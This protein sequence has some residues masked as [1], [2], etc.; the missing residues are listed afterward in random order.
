M[1]AR[2]RAADPPAP[3]DLASP[4]HRAL[5]GS[6]WRTNGRSPTRTTGE[7]SRLR[8][9]TPP[10]ESRAGD[11]PKTNPS[12]G[13][14]RAASCVALPLGVPL[15]RKKPRGRVGTAAFPKTRKTHESADRKDRVDSSDAT[16]VG[17]PREKSEKS[18]TTLLSTHLPLRALL[19]RARSLPRQ[20]THERN[21]K[22]TLVSVLPLVCSIHA[23]DPN[24][25]PHATRRRPSRTS[26]PFR[27][28]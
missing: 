8:A 12:S 1:R 27:A 4:R 11:F 20:T 24:A 9:F 17:T 5:R 10:T 16:G 18:E 6:G 3:P 14:S 28:Q 13:L 23:L 19:T 21:V 25:S 26:S 2:K 15:G 22:R 7:T